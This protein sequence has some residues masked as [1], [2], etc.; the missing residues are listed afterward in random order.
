MLITL[1]ELWVALDKIVVGQISFLAEYSPEI[2][3]ALLER[4][5]VRKSSALD[6]VKQLH[7]YLKARHSNA[8]IGLS[9]LS[10]TIDYRSFAVR[11]FYQSPKLKS[12]KAAIEADA[13]KERKEKKNELTT[14]NKRYT[15]VQKRAETLSHADDP[16]GWHYQYSCEK[17]GLEKEMKLMK[18]G[19][20]EWPLPV[21][22]IHSVIVV[23]ELACP[24]TC[25][26][27]DL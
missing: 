18:I 6:R 19:V 12:L 17:C 20:H 21:H 2:P 7:A 13:A 11:Y 22:E 1:F 26:C 10:S 5:L 3:V 14:L 9:V 16:R 15:T 25:T 8:S 24:I 4:L 23:F 27:G